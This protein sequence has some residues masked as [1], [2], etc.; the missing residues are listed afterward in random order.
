MWKIIKTKIKDEKL[1]A[2]VELYPH[3][4]H[5]FPARVDSRDVMGRLMLDSSLGVLILTHEAKTAYSLESELVEVEFVFTIKV[6]DKVVE[7]V[8]E[9]EEESDTESRTRRKT[10]KNKL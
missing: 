5:S 8:A 3:G 10:A 2:T 7:L 9:L 6:E 1:V 4:P